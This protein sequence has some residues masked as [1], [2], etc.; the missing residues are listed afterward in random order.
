ML[1]DV[2]R[3]GI[4]KPGDLFREV[5][6][7]SPYP[8]IN[9]QQQRQEDYPQPQ[10]ERKLEEDRRARRRFTTMREL[11]EQLKA[12]API[13]RVDYSTVNQE[14]LDLGLS[15]AED[16]LIPLLLQQKLPLDSIDDLVRQLQLQRSS[17]SLVGGQAIAPDA[18][19]FPIYV[20]DLAEYLMRFDGLK[21]ISGSQ[22]AQLIAQINE[23][24][25]CVVV[26]GR[27][28]L[29][30]SRSTLSPPVCGDTLALT[31]SIQI[32]AVEIDENGRR[33]IFYQR[34]DQSYGLY[35]DKSIS[36]SI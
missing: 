34:P 28:R 33:A 21:I 5:A 11:I 26:H 3:V 8:R 4:M 18:N 2:N 29:D 1:E 9:P 25:R 27:L 15:V 24:G 17:P 16:E 30:F 13:S 32:G 10:P 35:S 6:P 19:L 12:L 14:L 22:N 31:I 36:L 20:E 23:Q 7:V